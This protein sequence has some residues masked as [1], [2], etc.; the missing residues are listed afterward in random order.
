MKNKIKN[1]E[2]LILVFSLLLFALI[3]T[4]FNLKLLS[5]PVV[6]FNFII[7]FVLIGHVYKKKK[8]Y[9]VLFPWV[10]KILTLIFLFVLFKELIYL[11][12]LPSYLLLGFIFS[13]ENSQ[14]KIEKE[15]HQNQ[16]KEHFQQLSLTD[17]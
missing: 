13:K 7:S 14:H 1:S 15:N 2:T 9:L 17:S 8:N 3:E 12:I 10:F 16:L 11:T 6:A 4:Y 5:I